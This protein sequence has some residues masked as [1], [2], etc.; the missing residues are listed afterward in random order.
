MLHYSVMCLLQSLI[1]VIFV[2]AEGVDDGVRL[3]V[4][5]FSSFASPTQHKPIHLVDSRSPYSHSVCNILTLHQFTHW[6]L[7]QSHLIVTH[8]KHCLYQPITNTPWLSQAQSQLQS[9]KLF[10]HSYFHWCAVGD[11]YSEHF[12]EERQIREKGEKRKERQKREEGGVTYLI[13]VTNNN[14]ITSL[15]PTQSCACTQRRHPLLWLWSG[16]YD[17]YS[18][19]LLQ[20]TQHLPRY[21]LCNNLF[22]LLLLGCLGCWRRQQVLC[23]LWN[24][25]GHKKVFELF[26]NRHEN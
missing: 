14:N 20:Q 24:S 4:F 13:T 8:W 18:I 26:A 25:C 22:T 2:V 21:N 19:I 23:R 6:H 12:Q 17:H 16:T 10:S 11:H 7:Q 1:V 9:L 15:A 5:N 3:I